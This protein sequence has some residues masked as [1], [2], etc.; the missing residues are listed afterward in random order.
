MIKKIHHIGM[1]VGNIDETFKVF[2]DL[3]GF[4]TI[5]TVE[6]E[7]Q[8]L[9]S[10]LI[11]I[12]EA[13]IELIEP[14]GMEGRLGKYLA[15]RGNS[16]HHFSIEVDDLDKEMM[17]LKEKGIRLTSSESMIRGN[18]KVVFVH[19]D[20]AGGFLIELIQKR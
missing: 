18:F 20:S 19:P 17:R 8:K 10:S 12:N 11:G 14:I 3:F 1:A 16:L 13:A 5:M 4:K 7:Q 15:E 6:E 9:R 2:S